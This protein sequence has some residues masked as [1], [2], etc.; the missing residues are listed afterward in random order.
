[1]TSSYSA[2]L[3]DFFRLH[4]TAKHWNADVIDITIATSLADDT[5]VQLN[6][7]DTLGFKKNA[8]SAEKRSDKNCHWLQQSLNTNTE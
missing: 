5:S 7:S 2:A 4:E 8:P 1:M 6:L 3:D